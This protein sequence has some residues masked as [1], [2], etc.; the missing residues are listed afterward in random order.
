MT[1]ELS[2]A[3]FLTGHTGSQTL[4]CFS[5]VPLSRLKISSVFAKCKE[6][7]GEGGGEFR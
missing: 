4:G 5:E 1:A 2:S 7:V 6:T 3:V